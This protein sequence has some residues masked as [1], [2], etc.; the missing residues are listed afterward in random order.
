[1]TGKK[2]RKKKRERKG[3]RRKL[4]ISQAPSKFSN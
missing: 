1:M 3:R 4:T 2:E